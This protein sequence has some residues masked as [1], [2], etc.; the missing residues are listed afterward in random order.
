MADKKIKMPGELISHSLSPQEQLVEVI[1]NKFRLSIGI[2]KENSFQENRISLTPKSVEVLVNRGHYIIVET[3]AGEA[4]HFYDTDFSE[5]G[6]E[7]GYSHEDVFKCDIIIKAAPLTEDELKLLHHNQIIIS[8]IHLPTMDELHIRSMMDKKIT[9]L[10]YEWI[11]DDDGTFPIVRS[12]SEIAGNT[13]ILLAAYYLGNLRLG[14]G[15]LLGGMTGIPPAN[16]VILGAGTVGEYAARTALGLGAEVKIF[17]N[18]IYKLK[19]L[20]SNIGHRV[21]TSIILQ[22]ILTEA[23]QNADVAVGAI[24]SIDGRAPIIVTEEMVQKMKAGSVI[25]DVSIDQGGCF[26]TSELTNHERPYFKKYDVIHHCV[27]NMASRV[28]RTA[29]V[30]ISN[31]LTPALIEAGNAGGFDKLIQQH[32]NLRN[33]VYMFKGST[34]NKHIADKFGVKFMDLDLLFASTMY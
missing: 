17:D 8:P 15:I 20:Q 27:P 24:H 6:A 19:R 3:N 29:S 18:S 23:L 1:T 9:A 22:D 10:A 21:Y 4:A 33:G 30:A 2:P 11:K 34:T 25:I 16:I 13:S 31:V 7:I 5:A 32:A 14:K 28:P 26:E 12:M